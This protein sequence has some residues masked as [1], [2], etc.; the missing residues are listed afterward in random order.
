M[1]LLVV[2]LMHA[3]LAAGQLILI[4]PS[5]SKVRMMTF[6]LAFAAALWIGVVVVYVV[7]RRSQHGKLL[8]A[9]QE[10]NRSERP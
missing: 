1:S 8:A 6:D 2:M 4:S 7:I 10:R 9:G 3:P 5:I